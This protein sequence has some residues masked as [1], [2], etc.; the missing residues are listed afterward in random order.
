MCSLVQVCDDK[1]RLRFMNP[2]QINQLELNPVI[3]EKTEMLK[4]MSN[5][6]RATAIK[7]AQQKQT[8]ETR[9]LASNHIGQLMQRFEDRECIMPP[10][11]LSKFVLPYDQLY[12]MNYN[13]NMF[14]C[15]YS[16]HWILAIICPKISWI[17]IL[18][19]LDIDESKYKEFIECMQW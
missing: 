9:D 14:V 2:T 10:I 12:L 7:K 6:K 3:N 1:K 5:R 18:D 8:K 13:I 4:G 16:R 15:L 17:F 19:P 11:T